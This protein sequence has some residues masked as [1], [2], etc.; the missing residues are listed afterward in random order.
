MRQ[1]QRVQ[2]CSGADSNFCF[3]NFGPFPNLCGLFRVIST[4]ILFAD[5][6]FDDLRN[7]LKS[8][9]VERS[10]RDGLFI[11]SVHGFESPKLL[12]PT[13]QPIQ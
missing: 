2:I 10:F 3:V 6:S 7:I 12:K 9:R 5:V 1:R 4:F 11:S 8:S 13:K